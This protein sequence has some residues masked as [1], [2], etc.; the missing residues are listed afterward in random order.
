MFLFVS[1]FPPSSFPSVQRPVC[2]CRHGTGRLCFCE[3]QT[4][5]RL[6]N[7]RNSAS[8]Q[9]VRGSFLLWSLCFCR[10]VW[11]KSKGFPSVLIKTKK[12]NG[13]GGELHCNRHVAKEWETFRIHHLSGNQ[14]AI[15][16]HKG[17]Y[18]CAGKQNF[19]FLFFFS[20]FLAFR[21][22]WWSSRS[23]QSTKHREVGNFSDGNLL[24][25]RKK[26]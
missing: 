14:V 22:R 4:T 10:L 2:L 15:Q 6:G 13:G 17:K 21:K 9:W 11:Y 3:S 19:F 12:D 24:I 25:K 20:F 26:F 23:C 1:C 18:L 5:K 7:L 16:C 8:F